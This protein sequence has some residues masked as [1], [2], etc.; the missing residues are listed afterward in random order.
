[1]LVLAGWLLPVL[2]VIA[3]HEEM[4]MRGYVINRLGRVWGG[5]WNYLADAV[6]GLSV[7]WD[8]DAFAAATSDACSDRAAHL[9]CLS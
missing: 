7:V 5:R 1:M 9:D 6:L 8:R 4:I 2:P 3:F